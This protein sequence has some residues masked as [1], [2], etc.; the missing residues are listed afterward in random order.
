[1]VETFIAGFVCGIAAVAAIE[2]IFKY[3]VGE[4]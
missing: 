3:T 4:L 1:M 2:V